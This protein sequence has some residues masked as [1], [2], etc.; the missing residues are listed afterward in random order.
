MIMNK[1]LLVSVTDDQRKDNLKRQDHTISITNREIIFKDPSLITWPNNWSKND[2]TIVKDPALSRTLKIS[3]KSDSLQDAYIT[4]YTR[5]MLQKNLVLSI[6]L[7]PVDFVVDI[8]FLWSNTLKFKKLLNEL[9]SH[10][11]TIN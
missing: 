9:K 1:P 11:Y 8:Y 2:I 5:R 4:T 10:G 3:F 7:L 6:L